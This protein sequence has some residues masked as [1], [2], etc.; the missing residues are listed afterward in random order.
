MIGIWYSSFVF[1]IPFLQ[2]VDFSKIIIHCSGPLVRAVRFLFIYCPKPARC[3]VPPDGARSCSASG[4][5][6]VAEQVQTW[7]DGCDITTQPPRRTHEHRTD[8]VPVTPRGRVI[9]RQPRCTRFALA[10][11]APP[12][13]FAVPQVPRRNC[14]PLRLC[15]HFRVSVAIPGRDA[16]A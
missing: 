16:V 2:N 11:H 6:P 4:M 14:R 5:A 3:V 10:E 7:R 15:R 8:S 9:S 1:P 13:C 12:H